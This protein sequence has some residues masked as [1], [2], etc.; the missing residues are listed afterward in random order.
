MK[1]ALAIFM[2]VGCGFLAGQAYQPATASALAGI[3]DIISELRGLRQ[4]AQEIAQKMPDC[5]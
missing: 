1:K 3:S 4:A 5:R 2:L